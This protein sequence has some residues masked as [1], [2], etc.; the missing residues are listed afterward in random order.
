VR[1]NVILAGVGGQGLLA[2]AAIIGQAA[3]RLGLCVK[4]AEVHGM[5]QRGGVVQS[6]LRFADAPIHSPLVSEGTAHLI[7]SLEPMEALRYLPFL[8][9]DGAI[10]VSSAPFVNIPDYPDLAG[11]VD[12][13]DATGRAH[14]MNAETLA[15][16]AG[17]RQAANIVML[18]AGTPYLGIAK[19]ALVEE[20]GRFFA[21]K[22]AK[23]IETNR[24]AFHAG[25]AAIRASTADT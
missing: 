13:L 25:L 15:A 23:V 24:R 5:A 6:H 17:A 1:R 4:Q 2:V 16:D 22:G 12:A 8:A 7:L 18:G 19:T 3:T 20:V 9:L 11:V 21:A 10:V 14:T